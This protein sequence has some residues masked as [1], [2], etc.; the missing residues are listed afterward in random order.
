[1]PGRLI[2]SS[3]YKSKYKKTQEV[4]PFVF[5]DKNTFFKK[6]IIEFEL[7]AMQKE[8]VCVNTYT[9]VSFSLFRYR[10][11]CMMGI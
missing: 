7:S 4:G 1:M 3:I 5:L 10:I 8:P 11:A 6:V 2:S 9:C